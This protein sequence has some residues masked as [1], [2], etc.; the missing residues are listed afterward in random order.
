MD[1]ILKYIL[2]MDVKTTLLLEEKTAKSMGGSEFELPANDA[3]NVVVRREN[4]SS[5]GMDFVNLV[6]LNIPLTLVRNAR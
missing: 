5:W 1:A 4:P 6:T 2:S 3:V